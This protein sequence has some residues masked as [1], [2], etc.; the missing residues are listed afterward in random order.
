MKE[1]FLG[2]LLQLGIDTQDSSLR[3]AVEFGVGWFP[4]MK[5]ESNGRQHTLIDNIPAT[6]T[7][8]RDDTIDIKRRLC[9]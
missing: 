5:F 6:L 1:L 8:F 4:T 2:D 7:G 9:C 3:F